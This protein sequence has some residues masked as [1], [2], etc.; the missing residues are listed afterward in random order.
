MLKESQCRQDSDKGRRRWFS[1]E[2][3]DLIVWSGHDG[4]ISGFQL[5]YDKQKSERA[6]TWRQAA[7]FSHE[8]VDSGETNPAKNLSPVLVPDGLCP[9]DEIAD[10][11]FMRSSEIDPSIRSFI[12]EKFR[13]YRA[14][15]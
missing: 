7:G 14:S 11:F 13:E 4:V 15:I 10:L 8:R 12:T 9:I 6:L 5:C 3:F 2:D 1:D